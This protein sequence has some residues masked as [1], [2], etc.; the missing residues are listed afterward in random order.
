MKI[1]RFFAGTDIESHFEDIEVN[2]DTAANIF[3][4]EIIKANEWFPGFG[5]PE[6]GKKDEYK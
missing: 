2:I 6:S 5:Q 3:N 4:P 1:T